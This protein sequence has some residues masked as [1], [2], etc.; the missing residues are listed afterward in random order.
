MEQKLKMRIFFFFFNALIERCEH[1]RGLVTPTAPPLPP[2]PPPAPTLGHP[3]TTRSDRA[4]Q[5]SA[6]TSASCHLP[7]SLSF[8]EKHGE[9]ATGSQG[10]RTLF[11]QPWGLVQ[12]FG[13]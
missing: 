6:L 3:G 13:I 9:P 1:S 7:P 2:P 8:D 10:R 11:P 4:L 12:L 5:A